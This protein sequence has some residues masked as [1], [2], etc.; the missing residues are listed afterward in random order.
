M[1][2]NLDYKKFKPFTNS[3]NGE[4]SNQTIFHYRQEKELVWAEYS[5]GSIIKG[6]LIGKIKNAAL[7]FSYQH[8][9]LDMEI[10]TGKCHSI[11]ALNKEGKILLKENWEWT[12]KDFSKGES[13]LVEI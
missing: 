10:M 1:K 2:I 3:K 4:V 9:N 5:G 12:C 6:F 11:V 13:L 8:L 7:E